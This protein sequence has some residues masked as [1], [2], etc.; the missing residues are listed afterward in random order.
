[1]AATLLQ[2]DPPIP[3]QLDTGEKG[4]ALGWLDYGP[5]YDLLWIIGLRDSREVWTLNNKRIRMQDNVSMGRLPR[6]I[7]PAS[8]TCSSE[9]CKS[10]AH[11]ANGPGD[12]ASVLLS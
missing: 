7:L 11:T 12:R 6:N 4:L 10:A 1:M 9:P 5:D 2:L 8:H 3:V